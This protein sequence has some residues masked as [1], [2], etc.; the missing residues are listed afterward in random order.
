[1][2]YLEKKVTLEEKVVY[3]SG[4]ASKVH[5]KL[6]SMFLTFGEAKYHSQECMVVHK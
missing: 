3:F 6:S 4:Q 1:M 2:K 5:E